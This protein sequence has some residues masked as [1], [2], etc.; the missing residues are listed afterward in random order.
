VSSTPRGRSPPSARP[1]PRRRRLQPLSA[2][3]LPREHRT[4]NLRRGGVLRPRQPTTSRNDGSIVHTT[5]K[6]EPLKAE[7][8]AFVDASLEGE[9]PP[10]SQRPHRRP[11]GRTARTR[12]GVRRGGA[13]RPPDR[14]RPRGTAGWPVRC[15]GFGKART[16]SPQPV[17]AVL[18]RSQYV[19]DVVDREQPRL[20]RSSAASSTDC[21]NPLRENSAYRSALSRP[22]S[23]LHRNSP[24]WPSS[25]ESASYPSGDCWNLHSP[26]I[27]VSPVVSPTTSTSWSLYHHCPV[28]VIV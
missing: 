16:R 5:E 3:G 2:A 8:E 1:G 6:R 14:R 15:R 22:L 11:D 28:S 21:V 12:R 18:L 13:R 7:I 25:F 20:S 10:A 17:I 26:T 19:D 23:G 4:R 9:D 24:T 27:S